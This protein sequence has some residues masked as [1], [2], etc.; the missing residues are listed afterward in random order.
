M[1]GVPTTIPSLKSDPVTT[2]RYTPVPVGTL[3]V[4]IDISVVVHHSPIL[5]V[6]V[7]GS[8]VLSTSVPTWVVSVPYPDELR[9]PRVDSKIV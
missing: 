8:Y 3:S 6:S 4:E 9:N 2:H 5:V 7:Y 1:D